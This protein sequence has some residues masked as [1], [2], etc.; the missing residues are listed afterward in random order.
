M[1][2]LNE[3]ETLKRK[4]YMLVARH[5]DLKHDCVVRVSQLLDKK[6]NE[7]ER[8]KQQGERVG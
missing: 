7:Y 2:V 4:M 6:L 8:A 5:G 1:T 3:I